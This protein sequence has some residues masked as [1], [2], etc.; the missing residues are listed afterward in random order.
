M[1]IRDKFKKIVHLMIMYVKYKLD[2]WPPPLEMLVFGLQWLAVIIPTILIIGAVVGSIHGESYIPYLQKLMILMGIMLLVQT[3]WGHKLPLVIGPATVLLIG[4]LATLDQGA[5]AINTSIIIGGGILALLAGGGLFKYVEKLF[6][7]K[8]IIVIL[9]L[10]A[11]TLTPTILNLITAGGIV[12]PVNNFIFALFLLLI[13]FIAHGFL[14]GL[15][16]STLPL[17][18]MLLGSFGYY[19]I[20]KVMSPVQDLS[21]VAFP[22]NFMVLA[23]PDVGVVIAFLI[24][25]L[26][27]AINDLGSI[28]AIGSLLKADKM[29]DRVRRGITTTGLGN[30]LAGF[31][32]VIGPVNYSMSPGIIFSTKCA[33]RFTLIPVGI[34]L[35]ILSFSPMAIGIMS[36][37]PSPV[38]G[39]VLIYIMTAQ[40]GAA[41]LVG[42]E[43]NVFTSL[44]DGIIIGMPILLGTVLAFLPPTLSAQLPTIIRP[45]IAN[46]FVMGILAV[47][48]LEHIIYRDKSEENQE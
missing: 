22:G 11:F 29:K 39:A 42:V 46:G 5:G 14:K 33:S 36:N 4:V 44:D 40:I 47:L 17:W 26:A 1:P 21:V 34:I 31:L 45:I 3:L 25:F 6:T 48:L 28:Q 18:I 43:N 35:L 8:V 30:V 16:K 15:W 38:I 32:G 9:M 2:N 12:A 10:I 13:A 27:L 7:P 20:F 24:C 19:G 41:L 37:I 23:V